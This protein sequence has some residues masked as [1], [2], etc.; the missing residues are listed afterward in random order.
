MGSI[1]FFIW[2]GQPIFIEGIKNIFN[3]EIS[4]NIFEYDE[5]NLN[6]KVEIRQSIFNFILIDDVCFD[7]N[8]ILNFM[9]NLSL[10]PKCPNTIIFTH[11]EEADY[12]KKLKNLGV[13]GFIHLGSKL[14]TL[15]SILN[16]INKGEIYCDKK[17]KC[18]L[19]KSAFIN[20][21]KEIKKEV[22]TK[23]EKEVLILLSEGMKNIEI[24]K[25]LFLSI[26]TVETHKSHLIEKL[27]LNGAAELLK[28]AV[29]LKFM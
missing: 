7:K 19:L 2:S 24:A 23:R 1:N 5:N 21:Q 4:I 8:S 13:K 16:S 6:S 20:D 17:F 14:T 27:N 26:R 18:L 3:R 11:C 10:K 28:Y 9:T 25:K 22:L 12:L 15:P 29:K